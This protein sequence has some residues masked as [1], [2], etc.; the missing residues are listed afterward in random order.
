MEQKPLFTA[1]TEVLSTSENV[2]FFV[3]KD[4]DQSMTALVKP[5]NEK[6]VSLPSYIVPGTPTELDNSLQDIFVSPISKAAG[7]L[8]RINYY[9]KTT[10]ICVLAY[11]VFVYRLLRVLST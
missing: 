10:F 8:D 3:Q 11:Y 1:L 9:D 4:N 5:V 2:T 6:N 7:N